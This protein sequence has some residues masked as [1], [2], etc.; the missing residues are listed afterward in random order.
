MSLEH[1]QPMNI[2]EAT[3]DDAQRIREVH[4]AAF[5]QQEGRLVADCAV[6]LLNEQHP[7]KVIS[8]VATVDNEIVGHVAFSPV[9]H[10]GTDE[11][12]GYILA[13]LAVTPEF[14]KHKIGSSLVRYGLDA[15]AA[16][17]S[18]VVFVYGDPQYYARFGFDTELARKYISPY[19]LQYP[20]GWQALNL[21]AA[22]MTGGGPITCVAALNDPELW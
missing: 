17:G 10:A 18:F 21:G 7:V 22:V 16:M 13:P 8:L 15:I 19:T 2:R 14:Q 6:N 11:H 3:T 9:F 20:E 12:F 5:G 1:R 4:L